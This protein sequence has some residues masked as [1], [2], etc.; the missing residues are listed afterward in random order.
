MEVSS[1]GIA[2]DRIYGLSFKAGVFTNLTHDHL[3]YHGNFKNYRDTK[4]QFF[5]NL[6]DSAFALTNIDDKNGSFMLQNTKAK[7]TH[8][9]QNFTQTIW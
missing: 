4:K 7:N 3:D 8:M 2:Q 1:H 6:S 9:L 5:D